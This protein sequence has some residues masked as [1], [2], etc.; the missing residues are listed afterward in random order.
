MMGKIIA[1]KR[2]DPKTAPLPDPASET[3]LNARAIAFTIVVAR[4]ASGRTGWVEQ[5]K[6]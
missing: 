2:R 3:S 5:R 6:E 4:E 1:K